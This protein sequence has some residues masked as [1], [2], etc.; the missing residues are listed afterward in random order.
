MPSDDTVKLVLPGV[1]LQGYAGMPLA[2]VTD[3]IAAILDQRPPEEPW[4]RRQL[5]SLDEAPPTPSTRSTK[6]EDDRA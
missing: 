4:A 5:V 2:D 6:I 1:H 3:A